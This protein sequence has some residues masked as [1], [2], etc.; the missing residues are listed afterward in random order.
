MTLEPGGRTLLCDVAAQIEAQMHTHAHAHPHAHH[1]TP[2]ARVTLV[3]AAPTCVYFGEFNMSPPPR[4][5]HLPHSPD[6]E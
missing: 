3:H 1:F 5:S 6:A 4:G 2:L